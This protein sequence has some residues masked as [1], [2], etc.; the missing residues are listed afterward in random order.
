MSLSANLV[1][2]RQM[3]AIMSPPGNHRI[4][5]FDAPRRHSDSQNKNASLSG[6]VSCKRRQNFKLV[7]NAGV[8]LLSVNLARKMILLTRYFGFLSRRQRPA[9]RGAH[10]ACFAIQARFLPLQVSGLSRR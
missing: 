9:V 3:R 1:T 7:C 8:V 2:P 10:A 4:P 5:R 6:G